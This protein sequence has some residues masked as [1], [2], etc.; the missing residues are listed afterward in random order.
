[1]EYQGIFAKNDTDLVLFPAVKHSIDTG[2][3][4]PIKQ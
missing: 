1:M 3:A 4:K 2:T